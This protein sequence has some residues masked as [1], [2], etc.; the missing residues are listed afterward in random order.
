MT[1]SFS[2]APRGLIVIL[3]FAL[4]TLFANPSARADTPAP[5]KEADYKIATPTLIAVKCEEM[6]VSG[7]VGTGQLYDSPSALN[8]PLAVDIEVTPYPK[9]RKWLIVK[10]KPQSASAPPFSLQPGKKYKVVLLLHRPM[11]SFAADATPTPFDLDMSNTVVMSPAIA[12][13]SK[14]QYEFLSHFAYKSGPEGPCTLQVQDFSGKTEAL[15][16]HDCT[17]RAPIPDATRVSSP[18][19]LARAAESPEDLGSFQLTLD[20]G[21]K[22]T[23][24]LPASLPNLIDIFDKPVK[25]DAKSQLVPEKAPASKDSSNYYVNFNYGAGKGSK[26]GWIL[27]GKIAPVIGKLFRGYQFIPTASADVGINQIS[28]LKYTD[29]I[30]F[31]ASL[32]HMYQ[33]N[34]VLQGLL[35]KPGLTYESDREFDRHN[36]LGTTDL[37]FRFANLYNPRQRRNAIKYSEELKIAEAK[38][39][40]WTRA[41][42][43]PVLLGY[44]L[45]FH[46]GFEAGG[47]LKDTVVKASVG[48]A[49]LPLPSYHIGRVVP[50]AHALF[51]I[52]RFSIDAVGTAR[53]L[54]TAENTVLERPDHTLFLK[55][56]HGWNAYG[57][58]SGSWNFD[59]AG[60][61][62]FTATYKDG[63]SPP[64]FSR[65]NTVQSGITLKY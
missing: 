35:F 43:K 54:T 38:K 18:T 16:A 45:D 5:C 33:P 31:G 59:P 52:G 36:L 50:Q 57:V 34:D 48:K 12:V 14:D 63:F 29:T 46:I 6:D 32:A 55:R 40:P 21:N 64:K 51:E 39:I 41:N 2:V 20:N 15:K 8:T 47:A 4:V 17:V 44:V 56:L 37:Q 23:Q 61:F 49:T 26:P 30:N 7:F 22:G 9:A 27:D 25:I 60:H 11:E 28:N 65:V 42:S 13:S 3:V 58:I 62:A 19:D 24:Q 53:Y 1:F 10:L